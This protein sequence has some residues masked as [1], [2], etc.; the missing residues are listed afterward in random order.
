MPVSVIQNPAPVSREPVE[1]KKKPVQEFFNGEILEIS[2]YVSNLTLVQ[3]IKDSG[4]VKGGL[5][6]AKDFFSNIAKKVTDFSWVKRWLE[7]DDRQKIASVARTAAIAA[8][9]SAVGVQGGIGIL[10]FVRAKKTHDKGEV[11][12]GA[13]DVSSAVAAAGQLIHSTPLE[14]GFI[15][16]AAALS[17]ARG[18]KNWLKGHKA[19]DG[20]EVLQGALQ[21]SRGAAA[22]ARFGAGLWSGLSIAARIV[23]PVAGCI[24]GVRGFYD[25]SEGCQLNNNKKE[26]E[27]LCDLVSGVGLALMGTGILGIPGIVLSATGVVTK[28]GYNL[29]GKVRKKLDKW[30]DHLEPIF[31]K[32]VLP[33]GRRI[34]KPLSFLCSDSD[35]PIHHPEKGTAP[36]V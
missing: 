9:F 27:G 19:G 25:L 3:A 33:A 10:H 24:Q 23:G 12:E 16:L 17:I 34:L 11:L 32:T 6:G 29:S 28:V 36:K 7:E 20:R 31:H 13:V 21:S 30:I 8:G 4:D 15:P 22:L 18:G 26:L 1:N 35:C 5:S 14:L 2:N